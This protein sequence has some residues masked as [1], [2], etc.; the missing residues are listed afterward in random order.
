MINQAVELAREVEDVVLVMG[1]NQTDESEEHD[2]TDLVLPGRQQELIRSVSRAAKRPVILVLLCGGP[3]DVR[4]ARDDENVGSILWAGY[5]GEAGGYALA[6][7]LFGEHNP[8][9]KLP[10]TWYPQEF[11]RVPMTDMRMRPNMSADYPGRTY[12]FYQGE[13]VFDY[14][15]GLHYTKYYYKFASVTKDTFNLKSNASMTSGSARRKL[16]S[17][18]GPGFC[19]KSKS[20]V[21]VAVK[22][23][24]NMAGKHPVLL[25]LRRAVGRTGSPR[26]QL[27]DFQSIELKAGEEVEIEFEL[28]PCEHLSRANEDGVMVMEEG[29]HFLVVEE[30]EY[31]IAVLP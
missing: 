19:E 29:S 3:V 11:T 21:T 12:R 28:R 30:E 1:L 4:F 22:N 24:G 8:G 18:L 23:G 25:F 31:P 20:S 17:E 9:G 10:V 14:G 6:E 15:Y 26:K 27:V 16:V 7:V 2:R 13:T 5:P